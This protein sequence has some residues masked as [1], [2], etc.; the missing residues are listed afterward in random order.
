MI[1]SVLCSDTTSKTARFLVSSVHTNR[2]QSVIPI[3][4]LLATNPADIPPRLIRIV[5]LI[6]IN[7]DNNTTSSIGRG[8]RGLCQSL[9]TS[10]LIFVFCVDS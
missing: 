3:I 5:N 1:Y 4:I 9:S 7:I 6:C 2:D 8:V 10:H